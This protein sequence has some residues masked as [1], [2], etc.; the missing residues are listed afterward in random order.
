MTKPKTIATCGLCSATR[1][2]VGRGLCG[3]CYQKATKDGILKSFARKNRTFDESLKIAQAHETEE[4]CWP[5]PHT[6]WSGYPSGLRG[7]GR[8]KGAHVV[9][10]EAVNGPVPD[11]LTLDHLCHTNAEACAG[12]VE[13]PHRRCVNPAHLEPVTHQEQCRRKPDY[14]SPTCPSGHDRATNTTWTWH[15]DG[16]F[17]RQCR[18]CGREKQRVRT[19]PQCQELPEPRPKDCPHPRRP[20]TPR[21]S[22]TCGNG[23]EYTPE[24]TRLDKRGRRVCRR[25]HREKEAARKQGLRNPSEG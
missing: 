20:F 7:S 3:A 16:Y 12:G 11:G 15:R 5:W 10:W 9:S 21:S 23:H 2:I 8:N 13:C 25:C 1:P 14:R 6:I 4:G 17:Y 18:A 24:N 19:C 22:P